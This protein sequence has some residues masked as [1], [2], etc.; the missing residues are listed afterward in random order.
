VVTSKTTNAGIALFPECIRSELHEVRSVI[1][2]HSKSAKFENP[3][4]RPHA[5]ALSFEKGTIYRPGFRVRVTPASAPARE[6]LIDRW[7]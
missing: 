3:D 1:E 6:Y 7:D 5:V 4:E 2:A